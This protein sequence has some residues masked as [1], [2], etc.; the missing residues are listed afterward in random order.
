VLALSRRTARSF[1][2]FD[3]KYQYAIVGHSG[4]DPATPLVP[5]GKPPANRKERLKVR[6]AP[7]SLC[8]SADGRPRRRAAQVLMR[9][10][11]HAQY[12]SAGDTTLQ[13]VQDGVEMVRRPLRPSPCAEDPP[14]R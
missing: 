13:A 1:H 5:F 2:G 7:P 3:H 11:A 9:M 14:R 8:G 12:C 6:A 10:H 4:D